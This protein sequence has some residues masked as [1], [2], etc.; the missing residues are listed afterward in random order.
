MNQLYPLKFKPIFKEKIWGGHKIKTKLGLDFSPLPNC[1]EAW[2]LSGVAGSQTKVMNGFLKGNELNDLLEV[3]MDDLVGESVFEKHREEFPILIKLIDANDYLSIQVHPDDQF[4][5]KM[6]LGNGKTEFWYILDADKD[7][8]VIIGFN[9]KMDRETYLEYFITGKL[10]EIL[11]VEKVKKSDVLYIPAGRIHSLGPGLLLAEIQ[12]TSDTTYRIY[13]WDRVD[14]KG[15]SRELHTGLALDAI[16]F[17][18]Y[19]SYRTHYRKT[20]NKTETL[21]ESPYFTTNILEFDRT[22]HKDFSWLDSFV[23]YVC[24]EGSAMIHYGDEKEILKTGESLLLPAML[25]EFDLLPVTNCKL[26]EVFIS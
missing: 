24:T 1:G 8:E 21:V 12:Q 2:I 18:M 3:Y 26:L 13:D 10:K 5:A 23:I 4:A 7:A 22:V 9:R 20:L 17:T 16:D 15:N 11:N 14:D 6:N 19:D 25:K